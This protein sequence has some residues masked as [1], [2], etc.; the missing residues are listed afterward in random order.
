MIRIFTSLSEV[1]PTIISTS[2]LIRLLYRILTSS[3]SEQ[4]NKFFLNDGYDYNSQMN[5]FIVIA[6]V[7]RNPAGF[8]I[9]I[10]GL[11][12]RYAPRNDG[13]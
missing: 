8:T 7:R 1:I 12:R 6:S 9:E 3:A 11:P 2:C 10:S 5:H 13:L 4:K